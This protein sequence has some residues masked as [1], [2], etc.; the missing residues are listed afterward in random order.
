[1]AAFYGSYNVSVGMNYFD[2][3]SM[4]PFWW[5]GTQWVPYAA[6]SFAMT[7]MLQGHASPQRTHLSANDHV[8]F[9]VEDAGG[10]GNNISL[11]TSSPYQT[12]PGASIGR[13][14][15]AGNHLYKLTFN[16]NQ[17][18]GSGNIYFQWYVFNSLY[19]TGNAVGNGTR[20][21]DGFNV[22]NYASNGPCLAYVFTDVGSGG[23]SVA[24]VRILFNNGITGIGE[25]TV[26]PLYAWFL[27]EQVY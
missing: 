16:P 6:P 27:V 10:G 26:A 2:H 20:M 9:N 24:E 23:P 11:D 21:G 1:V 25:N 13:I 18:S 4:Q 5:D 8:L 7:N 3:H 19:P 12:R 17:I 14:S 15:L 22:R